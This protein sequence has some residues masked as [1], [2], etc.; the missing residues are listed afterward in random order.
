MTCIQCKTICDHEKTAL[1]VVDDVY[2]HSACIT[3]FIRAHRNCTPVAQPAW[4]HDAKSDICS[5]EA[6]GGCQGIIRE[7]QGFRLCGWHAAIKQQMQRK[8]QLEEP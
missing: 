4:D 2:M 7:V 1:I 6:S 8:G 5:A 3:N